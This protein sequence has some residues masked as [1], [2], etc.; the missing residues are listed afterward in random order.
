MAEKTKHTGI[1]RLADGVYEIRATGK[2]PRTNKIRERTHLKEGITLR[3]AVKLREAWA[4]EIR[5][6]ASGGGTA[7]TVAT[8]ANSWLSTRL[9]A[10]KPSTA[11]RYAEILELHVKPAWRDDAGGGLGDVY[12]DRLTP[13]MLREWAARHAR[14]DLALVRTLLRAAVLE[15]DLARDPTMGI[16]LKPVGA[17]DDEGGNMLDADELRRLLDAF[18]EKE[19]AWY[20]LVLTLALTGARWSEATALRWEDLDELA[21]VIHLRRGQWRNLVGTPKTG[22]TREPPLV[23]E[24]A[25][26]L[27]AHRRDLVERQ[28]PGVD[29]GYVFPSESGRLHEHGVLGKALR[30]ALAI[31]KIGKRF[32]VHGFRRTANN[33]L[34]QVSTAV[35][36]KAVVGHATDA[37]HGHYSRVEASEKQAAMGRVMALLGRLG[38]SAPA[39]ATTGNQV[40]PKRSPPGLPAIAS[41]TTMPPDHRPSGS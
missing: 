22:K 28:A 7:P 41:E 9:D 8:F 32:S 29:S 37:M 17:Y 4:T 35:V 5:Q 25:E 24:L 2:D 39:V 34:R 31:A 15:Y 36:T 23:P 19:P 27:R 30:H 40:G 12:L 20:P 6:G 33:L 26:V 11:H 14:N 13:T 38:N 18:R 10:L 1:V 16:K 21:G 3:E